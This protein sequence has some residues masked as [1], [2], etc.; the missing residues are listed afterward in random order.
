MNINGPEF[1]FVLSASFM[2]IPA[3]TEGLSIH[4]KEEEEE[5]I[6]NISKPQ[7][8]FLSREPVSLCPRRG[9]GTI[10]NPKEKLT[11]PFAGLGGSTKAYIIK[12]LPMDLWTE[13]Y[14]LNA[15][16]EKRSE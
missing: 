7:S 12:S 16:S 13:D 10:G 8:C 5:S 9:E 1:G 15:A 2:D 3:V 11:P 14:I 4:Y 6:L